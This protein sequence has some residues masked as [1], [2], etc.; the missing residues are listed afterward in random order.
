[1]KYENILK[2]MKYLTFPLVHSV[3]VECLVWSNCKKSK[4]R[5]VRSHGDCHVL[6]G[7]PHILGEGPGAGCL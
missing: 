4:T 6:M 5:Q 3:C 7:P 1:M 2:N